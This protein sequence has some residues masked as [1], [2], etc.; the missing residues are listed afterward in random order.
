MDPFILDHGTRW[1]WVVSFTPWAIYPQGKDT[2]YPLHTSLDGPQSRSGHGG[3]EKT[4][5]PLPGIEPYNR[6]RPARSLVAIYRLSYHA[7][8]EEIQS[9]LNSGNDCYRSVQTLYLPVFSLNIY[10][11]KYIILLHGAGYYLKSWLSLSLSKNITPSY[12]TRSFIT[13]F[14]KDHQRTLSWVR[15]IHSPHRSLPP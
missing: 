1:R 6:D 10:G 8:L 3:E 7:S 13:L 15:R 9:R 11:L 5:H 14:T 2:R 4:S 12:E